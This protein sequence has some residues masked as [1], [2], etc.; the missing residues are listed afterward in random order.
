MNSGFPEFLK[1]GNDHW[2]PNGEIFREIG[3]FRLQ[4]F[5]GPGA[6]GP[7]GPGA[8]GHRDPGALGP[9]GPGREKFPLPQQEQQELIASG[10]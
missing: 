4:G 9:W 1:L 10:L 3:V 2:C 7:W 8:L 6:Q 5:W